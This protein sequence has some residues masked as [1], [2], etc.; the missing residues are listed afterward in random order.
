MASMDGGT[1]DELLRHAGFLRALT[2]A[3]ASTEDEA[4]DLEQDTWQ[5]ALGACPPSLHSPR[6]WLAR[7]A[8]NRLSERR[9]AEGRRVRRE[10]RV[11]RP[12]EVV[13]SARRAEILRTVVTAVLELEE[14][15]RATVLERFFEGL[16]P[17]AIARRHGIPVAT[18]RSRIRRAL[19]ML[20]GRLADFDPE[21]RDAW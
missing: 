13:D 17:R 3:L 14:P 15:W 1:R 18:V 12:E 5:R 7:I 16:P 2:R 11:A 8:R 4:E 20:R 21:R 10:E 19:E 9:R 6:G